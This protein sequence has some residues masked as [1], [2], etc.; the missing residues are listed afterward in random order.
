MR[1]LIGNILILILLSSYSRL[2]YV[3]NHNYPSKSIN[4][5][6]TAF[7]PTTLTSERLQLRWLDMSDAPALYAMFADEEAT[8]YLSM[9]A[10]Q[11]IAKAQESIQRDIR[12]HQTGE[13]LRFGVV[14]KDTQQLIGSCQIFKIH[15]A[16]RRAECGYMLARKHWHKGYASEAMQ[17][18]IDYCFN[19]LKLNRLEADIDPANVAS[20]QLL[21]R[22]GFAKE[23]V[24]PERWIV[25]GQVSDS[26][27]YGLLARQWS[28]KQEA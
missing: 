26:W 5:V 18:L 13:S 21:Q 3:G 25:A 10:W 15:E 12:E 27:I 17:M 7:T 8:R 11:T 24:L 4:E 19:E 9:P 14:L 20:A 2:D 28:A 23:G 6:M 16:S 22:L 1:D